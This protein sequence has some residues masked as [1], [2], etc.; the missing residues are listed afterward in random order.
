[1]SYLN[2]ERL[3][4]GNNPSSEQMVGFAEGEMKEAGGTMSNG[5]K[6]VSEVR[7][8]RYRGRLGIEWY[9]DKE[10][11]KNAWYDVQG[12]LTPNALNPRSIGHNYLWT[13]YN[14]P[15]NPKKYSGKD[16]YSYLPRN[17]VE[18]AGYTHD[19]YYDSKGVHGAEGLFTS[20]EVIGA[21]W[22]FVLTQNMNAANSALDPISRIKAA[23]FAVGLGIFA[24][25]KTV[26][27]GLVEAVKLAGPGAS[28]IKP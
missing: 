21:D 22:R 12:G 5:G 16:D 11:V 7:E 3:V 10:S 4:F 13:T 17:P 20:K 15:N 24:A 1:M 8:K 19:K 27:Y 9:P 2:F 26:F 6:L 18:L 28:A 25:P 23:G 14:G